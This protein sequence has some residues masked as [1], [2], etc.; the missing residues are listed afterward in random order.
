MRILNEENNAA[1]TNI[2]LML[3]LEEAKELRDGLD[4]LIESDLTKNMHIHVSDN[5]YDHEITA[6]I[7]SCENQSSFIERIKSLIINDK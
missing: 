1:T 3:T 5:E 4:Q 2:V 6:A 7:Y